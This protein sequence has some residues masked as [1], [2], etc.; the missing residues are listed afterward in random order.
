MIK[1]VTGSIFD[2]N[3][4][5]L[6][7]PVNC[8]GVMGAGLAKQFKGKYPKYYESYKEA[9]VSGQL[10]IGKIHTYITNN[11]ILISF[12]TKYHWKNKT[13]IKDVEVGLNTLKIVLDTFRDSTGLKISS[14]AIPALGCG[15]G[16]LDWEEVK[17]LIYTILG[18]LEDVEI[19]L[20]PPQ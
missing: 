11:K 12:P 17:P 15:L 5:A 9:C 8:V 18:N 4:E 1:E 19:L 14:V 10:V 16:G 13:K 3:V 2:A 20:Y 7:N 6:V